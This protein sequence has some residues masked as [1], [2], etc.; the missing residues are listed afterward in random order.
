MRRI[1][2][3]LVAVAALGGIVHAVTPSRPVSDLEY[4]TAQ[5]GDSWFA[6]RRDLGLS[7]TH[8]DLWA[9]NG[10]GNLLVGQIV[11]IPPA[12]RTAAPATT[13]TSTTTPAP[14]TSTTTMPPMPGMP[15]IDTSRI[16]APAAGSS[17]LLI[18]PTQYPASPAADGTGAFRASCNLS[19]FNSDDPIIYPGQRG[20]SHLH[21]YWGRTGV[22]AASTAPFARG[23]STCAGGSANR[24]GYWMPAIV[25]TV[26]MRPVIPTAPDPAQVYYKTGY[27]GVAN[28]EVTSPPADLRIVAGDPR[29]TAP[30]ASSFVNF[31]CSSGAQSTTMPNCPAGDILT[32]T[33]VFPQCWNGRDLD[34]PDHRSHMAYGRWAA[35]PDTDP[36]GCPAS[37]PVPIPEITM[38]GRYL[39][40]AGGMASWRLATDLMHTGPAGS[41]L[42]ADWWNG[43]DPAFMD[44]IVTNCLNRGLDGSMNNLCDGFALSIG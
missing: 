19:H 2:A 1:I 8:T 20:A 38:N 41:S 29:A 11:F 32:A 26:T 43:W 36:G 15:G 14:A 6:I 10:G 23:A 39:V 30:Q 24:S 7:C 28:A 22:N 33:V 5:S 40:P 16:P 37:H 31:R 25:D 12:C 4:V 27:Q 9:A 34:S 35:N 3:V 17:A 21:V 42:H 44:R 13:S 18:A